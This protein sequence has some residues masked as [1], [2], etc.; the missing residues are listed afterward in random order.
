MNSRDCRD[1]RLGSAK[2]HSRT[3]TDLWGLLPHKRY[4]PAK[5]GWSLQGKSVEETCAL[6][7]EASEYC[8][9]PYELLAAVVLNENGKGH[10]NDGAG[11]ACRGL[12]IKSQTQQ[13]RGET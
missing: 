10:K 6:P 13:E 12:V 5:N 1:S 9:I 7:N 11:V 3:V 4:L 8:A 2:L